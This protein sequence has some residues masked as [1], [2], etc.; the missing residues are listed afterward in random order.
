MTLADMILRHLPIG[1]GTSPSED[2]DATV[3]GRGRVL[4]PAGISEGFPYEEWLRSAV[5]ASLWF[6]MDRTEAEDFVAFTDDVVLMPFSHSEHEGR[7]TTRIDGPGGLRLHISVSSSDEDMVIS[8]GIG[9][10]DWGSDGTAMVWEEIGSF[11]RWNPGC[12]TVCI[13]PVLIFPNDG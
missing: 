10:I 4:C 5:S 7:T 8:D 9:D 1:R 3:T 11:R 13:R 12:T 2:A 6:W